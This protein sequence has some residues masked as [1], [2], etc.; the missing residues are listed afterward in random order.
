M[1]ELSI[2]VLNTCLL[3]LDTP[4]KRNQHGENTMLI[5][6]KFSEI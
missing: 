3:C 4:T 2:Y 1:C 5:C 6:I